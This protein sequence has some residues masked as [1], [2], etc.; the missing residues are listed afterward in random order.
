MTDRRTGK[1]RNMAY[2]RLHNN[3]WDSGIDAVIVAYPLQ[4]FIWWVYLMNAEQC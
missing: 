2:R 1:T 3:N 4:E